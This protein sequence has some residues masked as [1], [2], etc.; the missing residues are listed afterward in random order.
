MTVSPGLAKLISDRYGRN[1]ELVLNAPDL[2]TSQET[3]PLR[4]VTGLPPEIS[5]IVYIGGIAPDRGAETLLDSM[6]L[7]PDD[8]HLVFVSNST[9]GYVAQLLETAASIGISDRVH[10]APYVVPEAVVSYIRS[11]DASVIPLS[12]DVVNYEVALPNKLFQSIHAGVPVAVSDNPEM[13]RFVTEHEVGEVFEG[14][15]PESMADAITRMLENQS[16]YESK[17]SDPALLDSISWGQQMEIL[18]KVY[19]SLGVSAQ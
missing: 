19:G 14:G 3:T 17:L 6:L 16:H 1:A 18:M 10:I 5:I 4:K 2:D 11:A 15:K 12:R 9:T 8:V 7:L 13:A